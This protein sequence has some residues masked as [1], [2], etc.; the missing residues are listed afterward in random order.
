MDHVLYYAPLELDGDIPKM[1]F[2]NWRS[3]IDFI[4]D[5]VIGTRDRVFVLVINYL[6]G[7]GQYDSIYIFDNYLD[8]R[9]LSL[10]KYNSSNHTIHLHEYDSYEEAYKIAL[11]M[12][13]VSQLCYSPT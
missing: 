5:K 12:K 8:I 13:E 6:E 1:V 3:R 9:F 4:S 10:R 11:D 2:K 7:A